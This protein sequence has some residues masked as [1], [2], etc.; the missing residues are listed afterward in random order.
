MIPEINKEDEEIKV[1]DII[2]ICLS[3]KFLM[4]IFKEFNF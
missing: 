2:Y 3:L 1:I 4:L